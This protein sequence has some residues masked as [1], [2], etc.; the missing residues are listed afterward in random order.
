MVGVRPKI[1]HFDKF[2]GNVD[3]VAYILGIIDYS[4]DS[5]IWMHVR[6]IW[7]ATQVLLQGVLRACISLIL[8]EMLYSDCS[9][10]GGLNT[11]DLV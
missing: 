1:L 4:S 10:H 8:A 5:H 3:R 2:L 11:I 6:I 7:G 9:I